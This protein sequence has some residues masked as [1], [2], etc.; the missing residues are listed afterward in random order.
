M[1]EAERLREENARLRRLLIQ[2]GIEIPEPP[3][4]DGIPQPNTNRL[5]CWQPWY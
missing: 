4:K 2:H 5:C 3:S 1:T